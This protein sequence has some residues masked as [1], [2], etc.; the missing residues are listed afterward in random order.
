MKIIVD[1]RETA[2][3]AE[4]NIINSEKHSLE[5]KQ[6]SIGDI[7]LL[8]DNN[9]LVIIIER[10]TI[11]DLLSSLNDG[12]YKEQSFRLN[13][14]EIPNKNICYIL[15]GNILTKDRNVVNG[16]M[17]SLSLNKGFTILTTINTENTAKMIL[18]ICDKFIINTNTNTNITNNDG[19]SYCDVVNISKKSKITTENIDIIMLSQIPS[20]SVN[21]A[22]TIL[23]QYKTIK[24]LIK[25][26]EEN[27]S[28]LNNM[29]Y[30]NSKNQTRKL[31]KTCI[32]NILLYLM[33]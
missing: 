1:S 19:V 12:R 30:T 7:H 5:T 2:L 31:N 8:D 16:C 23:D 22:K 33:K 3:I 15:E 27:P 21:N 10:K 6:L 32:S 18:K 25:T 24:N 28:A 29:T 13:E 9:N 4:F 20:V 26:L 14:C 17:I 11:K